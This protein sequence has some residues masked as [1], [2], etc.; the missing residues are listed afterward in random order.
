[1]L[2]RLA[3][4]AASPREQPAPAAPRAEAP[5]AATAA[6][7]VHDDRL[8]RRLS[9]AVQARAVARAGAPPAG[10]QPALRRGPATLH[11]V[12]TDG[13][14]GDDIRLARKL[15]DRYLDT[16]MCGQ[17]MDLAD[18]RNRM[19]YKQTEARLVRPG[20]GRADDPAHWL[21][22][23]ADLVARPFG[24]SSTGRVPIWCHQSTA[25]IVHTLRSDRRFSSRLDIVK[26][27]NPL[28]E[29]HWYVLANRMSRAAPKWGEQLQPNEFIIDIWGALRLRENEDPEAYGATSVVFEGPRHI[30]LLDVAARRG[31]PNPGK[32]RPFALGV[33]FPERVPP[34]STPLEALASPPPPAP[35]PVRAAPPPPGAAHDS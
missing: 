27:G 2:D 1:M 9:R 26:Q 19:L 35:I 3:R 25:I 14:V 29:G 7:V 17:H 31:K 24:A 10:G 34:V 20:V 22:T 8:G 6:P 23:G 33:G 21:A 30:A 15:L 32:P 12:L 4:T 28:E 16:H 13:E 5:G 18:T 11:R